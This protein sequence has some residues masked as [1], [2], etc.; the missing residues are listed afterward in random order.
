[1][2]DHNPDEDVAAA[3]S[4]RQTLASIA[5]AF[6]MF[7]MVLSAYYIIRPVREEF[8]SSLGPARL[9][10]AFLIVFAVMLAAVPIFGLIV[11]RAPRRFVLPAIYAFFALN[12][13]AF[14]LA[15]EARGPDRLAASL[16]FV[17]ASVFNLF[18]VSLFWSLMSELWSNAEASRNYGVIAAGG[19]AGAVAGPL[20]TQ[21]LLNYLKPI[22]LLLVSAALLTGAL[23]ASLLFRRARAG[24]ISDQKQETGG[25]VFDG[26]IKLLQSPY[27]AHIA[28]FVL[29]AN[30]V[31]TFFYLEQSRLVAATISESAD[32]V[33]FFAGRDLIVSV[34]TIAIQLFGT[35]AVLRR[36]G[37]TAALL[38]LPA[39]AAIGVAALAA[40]P[41]LTV[42][43]A[44]MVGE[45]VAAFALSNPAIKV[46]YTLTS[47]DEK[48]KAQN[49]IDTVV[50]RGGDATSGWLYQ[51]VGKGA[52]FAA[53][54][55]PL[56]AIPLIAIW[57]WNARELG[58]KH[59]QR[60]V[61]EKERAEVVAA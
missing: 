52:G 44:V 41:T 45:R 15:F 8:G 33:R 27:L 23:F 55:T 22:D 46:M 1:M 37:V 7:F 50:Y 10:T 13:V 5:A 32:R 24:A 58:R 34:A 29:L 51:S 35:A 12:L 42:V 61:S 11:K 16:F 21:A 25:G 38:A 56:I 43:A 54:T 2:V 6:S 60:A 28:L 4:N 18:V 20:M 48:Y 17:W 31:G 40:D 9:Q 47:T 39:M 26:A 59:A 49:F 36:F 14:Y 57:M 19:S 30:V 53:L 3:A